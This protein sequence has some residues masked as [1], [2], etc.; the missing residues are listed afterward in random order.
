M[1]PGCR[2]T[3]YAEAAPDRQIQHET[4]QNLTATIKTVPAT[5]GTAFL[6]PNT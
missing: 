5:A 1:S 2:L 3:P 4:T 6:K